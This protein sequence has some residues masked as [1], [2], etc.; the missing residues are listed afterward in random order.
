MLLSR[1][2]T[3]GL[4]AGKIAAWFATWAQSRDG[5][6]A[7]RPDD[8]RLPEHR[9]RPSN[10]P[11]RLPAGRRRFS[12]KINT[13]WRITLTAERCSESFSGLPAPADRKAVPGR[14]LAQHVAVVPRFVDPEIFFPRQK[15]CRS[16]IPRAG[17][18]SCRYNAISRSASQ[19]TSILARSRTNRGRNGGE[20]ALHG[21]PVA[22]LH[23]P[24]AP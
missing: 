4:P 11:G 8:V 16:L 17:T 14:C 3:P 21:P 18:R 13:L 24:S 22:V 10:W 1:D 20:W 19:L 12:A 23:E 2:S 7:R 9:A 15:R 6:A 5:A